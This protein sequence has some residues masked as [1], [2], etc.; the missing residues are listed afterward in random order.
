MLK[1]NQNPQHFASQFWNDKLCSQD[2]GQTSSTLFP[3]PLSI[4]YPGCGG[5]GACPILKYALLSC[6]LRWAHW[7]WFYPARGSP[8]LSSQTPL[9]HAELPVPGMDT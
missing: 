1:T 7:R 3:S 5:W 2:A 4:Q 8:G 9:L 6:V